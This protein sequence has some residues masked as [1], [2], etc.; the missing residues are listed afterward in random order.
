MFDFAGQTHIGVVKIFVYPIFVEQT[1]PVLDALLLNPHHL[2]LCFF[3]HPV[4]SSEICWVVQNSGL[5]MTI[6]WIF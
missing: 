5:Q 6:S 2:W 1:Y 4:W 3:S